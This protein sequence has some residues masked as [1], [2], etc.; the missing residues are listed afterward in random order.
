MCKIRLQ[1]SNLCSREDL[2]MLHESSDLDLHSLDAR[3]LP[4][5]LVAHK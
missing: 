2:T 4:C 1:S 5:T 3:V